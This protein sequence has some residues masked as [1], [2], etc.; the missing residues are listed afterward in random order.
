MAKICFVANHFHS[1]TLL[2]VA[3]DTGTPGTSPWRPP[4]PVGNAL[5]MDKQV[6]YMTPLQKIWAMLLRGRILN[7]LYEANIKHPCYHWVSIP[8][9]SEGVKISSQ[10]S[11]LDSSKLI[12]LLKSKLVHSLI[13]LFP[14][15][16]YELPKCNDWIGHFTFSSTS[17]H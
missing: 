5:T 8:R 16:L 12:G 2:T 4:S 9:L 15:H 7:I 11:L 6:P 17:I 3:S 13:D 10:F 14:P 1:S